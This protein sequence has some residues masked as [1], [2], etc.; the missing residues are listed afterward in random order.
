MPFAGH[1]TLGSCT[2]W[3]HA[4]GVPKRPNKVVQECSIGLIEIDLT[5]DAPGFIAPA[6]AVSSLSEEEITKL[7]Q[8]LNIDRACVVRSARLENGPIWQALELPSAEAVLALDS[9]LVR[10]PDYVGVS[11]LGAYGKGA[12]CQY[13]IRNLSPSS[14]M[15]EDPV[16][17]SLNAAIAKWM[18]VEGR[19]H[20]N[21]TMG[22]GTR[23]GREGRVFIRP[24]MDGSDRVLIGGH[25]QI[26]ID[27]TVYF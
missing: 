2:A 3:L 9:S 8:V 11:V 14:G 7:C 25:T 21:L 10:W 12:E 13:E 24:M 4:G 15:S 19:L 16:T 17:G 5:G 1:P 6:T 23:L 26:V 22:Q 18:Q 27:G 20:S